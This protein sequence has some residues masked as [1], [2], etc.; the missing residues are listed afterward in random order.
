MVLHKYYN[1]VAIKTDVRVVAINCKVPVNSS[2]N[3]WILTLPSSP[4][5]LKSVIIIE[6]GSTLGFLKNPIFL[7]LP[8][9]KTTY[10]FPPLL[11]NLPPEFL[12]YLLAFNPFSQIKL[13]SFVT[14]PVVETIP[15]LDAILMISP[16]SK[17][18]SAFKSLKSS[19]ITFPPLIKD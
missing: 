7:V 2:I 18:S 19:V 3:L 13:D 5:G 14:A 12:M 16:F 10:D 15:L 11:N 6:F 4:S 9:G 1:F 8:F 17:I